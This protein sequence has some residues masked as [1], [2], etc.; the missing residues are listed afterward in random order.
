VYEREQKEE[1]RCQLPILSPSLLAETIKQ[2]FT[3]V[4]HTAV[5]MAQEKGKKEEEKEGRTKMKKISL[6]SP[7]SSSSFF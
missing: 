4:S 3:S 1:E 2:R 5:H 6:L 7:N